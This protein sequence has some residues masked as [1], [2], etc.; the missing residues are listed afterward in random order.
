MDNKEL[1]YDTRKK[2][3]VSPG[4][5]IADNPSTP[6]S[7]IL[8]DQEIEYFAQWNTIRN[9]VNKILERAKQQDEKVA[10]RLN[11]LKKEAKMKREKNKIRF[12]DH[13]QNYK[14]VERILVWFIT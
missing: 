12:K 9:R 2:R 7:R 11:E 1:E 8:Q 13:E 6:A 5:T 14:R 10:E 3:R 4:R